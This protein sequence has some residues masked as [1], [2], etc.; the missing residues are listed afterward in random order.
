[1]TINP[2]GEAEKVNIHLRAI[3]NIK[4]LKLEID[5]SKISIKGRSS[6][7]NIVTKKS[8]K[9]VDLKESG[10]S[11]LQAR[12]IWYDTSVNRLNV[13]NRGEYIG[14]FSSDDRIVTINQKGVMEFKSYELINHFSDDLVLIEKYD[15]E[16]VIS[17]I[18][19]DGAKKLFYLKRFKAEIVTKPT[20]LFTGKKDSYLENVTTLFNPVAKL[21]FKKEVG[22]DRQFLNIEIP[23]FISVKSQNAKGKILSKK[24]IIDIEISKKETDSEN[25]VKVTNDKNPSTAESNF[26]NQIS[27][28]L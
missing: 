26:N 19:F 15:P 23:D 4:N 17:I 10:I 21:T 1:M 22:K 7:G 18:Y 28:N 9:R 24:K 25:L 5:F 20:L 16:K 12:K 2:N 6:I 11:T 8:V 14:E 27:L 13:D 3:K